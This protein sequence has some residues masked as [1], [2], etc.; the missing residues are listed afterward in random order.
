MRV[1][2][3]AQ[4]NKAESEIKFSHDHSEE[5]EE[6]LQLAQEHQK[7]VQESTQSLEELLRSRNNMLQAFGEENTSLKLTLKG[8][9]PSDSYFIVCT[10]SLR[11]P[12][13]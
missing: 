12:F 9:P 4:L 2:L 7:M 3:A 10:S 11:P 6:A 1:L 8:I 13:S 5:L